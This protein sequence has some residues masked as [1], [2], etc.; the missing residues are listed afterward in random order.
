[1]RS[2]RGRGEGSVYLRADGVWCASVTAGYDERGRRRRRVVYGASKGEALE[3][4]AK[5]Q[6][7]TV[8]GVFPEP[9]RMTVAD[10]LDRWLEDVAKPA[11][12]L[13]THEQY[14][15]VI[16]KHIKRRIGGVQ[17]Q[18]LTPAHLQGFFTTMRNDG[19]SPRTQQIVFAPLRSALRQALRWGLIPRN[20]CD[21]VEKP[22]APRPQF[23]VLD[24]KQTTALLTAARGN[25]LEALYVLAVTTGLRQG[26]MLGL[27]WDDVDL[28][29]RT[30]SVRHTLEE[31]NRSGD[32]RLVEPKTASARRR[33]DLLMLAVEA[34]R[35]HRRAMLAD[36]HV[37]GLVFRD[38]DGKPIRKSNLTRRS[39]KPLLTK[40][41]LPDIRFHDLRHTAATLLLAEGVH[42][43][44]VQERLGHA[45]I[46]VTLDTYSHV[47]PSMQR[48]ATAR[49]DRL[50]RDKRG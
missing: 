2:R 44:V 47:L 13:R 3:K 30:L 17:L 26:E 46:H 38:T 35:R 49:L 29:A 23:T 18:K 32:L 22:R 43:K 16:R 41:K 33:V 20:P 28:R 39:F 40:A 7:D 21:A 45:Q 19:V 6:H 50:L 11:V 8:L 34:L 12:R 1:M 36:G 27:Q 14:E 25:R 15:W 24:S 10:F 5:A 48:D 31:D 37:G 4:L 9:Q 42:P